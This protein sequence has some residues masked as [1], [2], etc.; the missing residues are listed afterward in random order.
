M[1]L[2]TPAWKLKKE[3]NAQKSLRNLEKALR[4]IGKMTNQKKLAKIAAI[5]T[6]DSFGYIR[7]AVMYKLTDQNLLAKI[8]KNSSYHY[9]VRELAMRRLKGYTKIDIISIIKNKETP[10]GVRCMAATLL[11]DPQK[12][13][14]IIRD[15]VS[16]NGINALEYFAL[17]SL[18]Q[19]DCPLDT[20]KEAVKMFE[21]AII[22][23]DKEA[24]IVAETLV[25]WVIPNNQMVFFDFRQTSSHDYWIGLVEYSVYYKN[26]LITEYDIKKEDRKD[27]NSLEKNYDYGLYSNV[28]FRKIGNSWSA[29]S[30][31]F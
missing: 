29:E 22:K 7:S 13:F 14:C 5:V 19:T 24:E 26:E 2:F 27:E 11:D 23:K 31:S 6:T 20:K 21:P 25:R 9:Y 3:E 28:H 30:S 10:M 4:A 1:G 8:A 16:E 12:L 17:R 15:E 18:L